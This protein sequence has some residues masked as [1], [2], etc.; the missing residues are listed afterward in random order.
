MEELRYVLFEVCGRPVT[1]YALLL[2][3][4]CAAGVLMLALVQKRAGLRSDTAEIYALLALPLGLVGARL[5]YCL[6]QWSYYREIG[7]IE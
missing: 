5:F 2:T 3:L 6:V 4:A 1:L 7:L